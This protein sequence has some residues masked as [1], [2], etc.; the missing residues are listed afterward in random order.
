[1]LL[2]GREQG[3]DESKGDTVLNLQ[4]DGKTFARLILPYVDREQAAA[5]ERNLRM[6]GV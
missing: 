5:W 2:G 3:G 1:M 4:V 6:S